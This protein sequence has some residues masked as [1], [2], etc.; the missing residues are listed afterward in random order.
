MRF[1]KK[2]DT[3]KQDKQTGT[4]IVTSINKKIKQRQQCKDKDK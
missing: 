2:I 4:N 1:E 3:S